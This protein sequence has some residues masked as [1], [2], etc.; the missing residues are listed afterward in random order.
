MHFSE[1]IDKL[2]TG[3]LRAA[4]KVNGRWQAN[5]SVKTAILQA[6][7]EG[8]LCDQDGFVDKHTLYAQ[9]FATERAVRFVPGGSS[10]RCGAYIAPQT[11]IMPP[12]FVNIG[13]Y[14]DTGT[15]IDSHVLVGSCA[16]IGKH[17]HLSA[18]VQ[19][20]G[21]L[22]P[23][24]LAPVVIEDNCFIGAGAIIVEGVHVLEGAVIAPM[25]TLSRS[26]AVF[27]CVNEKLLEPLSPIPSNAVV[28]PGSRA[29]TKPSAWA[30]SL[31]LSIN[32]ALIV[33]YR[34]Q[35]TS[36]AL[37]LEESLR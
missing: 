24:G 22:E 21:V 29:L 6:F 28:V 10:V 12:S 20:G 8:Q 2:T 19:I 17:V 1:V 37:I 3:E 15:M 5:H 27:D 34:D 4:T 16:Q 13:A 14:V 7:K 35:K 9:R 31:G 11:I 36:A 26:I 32:C 30:N 33:K 18:G 25:V 23:V